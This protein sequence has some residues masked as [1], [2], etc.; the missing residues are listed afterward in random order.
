MDSIEKLTL[1]DRVVVELRK[2]RIELND[3][4]EKRIEALEAKLKQME[5]DNV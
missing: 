5:K 3:V 4:I 2:I 1:N